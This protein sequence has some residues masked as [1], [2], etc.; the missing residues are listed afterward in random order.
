[1]LAIF[2]RE[3]KSYFLSP[4]G[5]IFADKIV[6]ENE[7]DPDHS[8]LNRMVAEKIRMKIKE[9]ERKFGVYQF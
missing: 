5:Y 9:E 4:I 2:K 1:M 7:D 8:P 3:F 6:E